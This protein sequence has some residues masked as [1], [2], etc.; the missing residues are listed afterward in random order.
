MFELGFFM[1]CRQINARRLARTLL[2]RLTSLLLLCCASY[3]VTPKLSTLRPFRA[4][5]VLFRLVVALRSSAYTRFL[6][7][8]TY[9]KH[10]FAGMPSRRQSHRNDRALLFEVQ[11]SH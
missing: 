3:A 8:L 11:I 9:G 7:V 2:K 4:L 6:V 10:D 1:S 5:E